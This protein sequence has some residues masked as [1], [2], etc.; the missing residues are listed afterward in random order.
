M[1]GLGYDLPDQI[2][3]QAKQALGYEIKSTAPSPPDIQ[4]LVQQEPA[5]W[6]IFSCFQQDVAEFW[7]WGNLQPVEIARL[8][9]W[10]EITPLYKLGR[11]QPARTRCAYGQGDAAF[12]RLYV[13]PNRSGRW[14][15]A[16]RVPASV[17]RELVQWVNES[18]A[19]PVGPE[20]KFCTGVPGT[21]NFDSFG[22]NSG[23]STKQPEKLSWAELLNGRW[24]GRV[25]LNG[26]DSQGG[27][28]DMA[29]AVQAAGLMR[30]GDLGDPTRKEIDRLA[31]LLL[32]YRKR[33]QF[34]NVWPQGGNPVEW[35]QNKKV[36]VCT[37]YASMIASLSALGFPVRQAD[38]PEGYRAFGGLLSISKAVTDPVQL[39]A[40]YDF[41]N[42][43]HS[44]FAGAFLLRAGY[45]N[46]VQSTSRQH[47]TPGEYA[48]WMDGK[49]A[50]QTYAG[51]FGDKS[52]AEGRVRDGGSFI[53]R[54][55]RI[56]SWNSTPRQQ[57]YF[58]GRWA[59]FISSFSPPGR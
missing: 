33:G 58:I 49:P 1:L 18:T 4:H 23:S 17:K 36:V 34:F 53:R 19:K 13:D 2:R 15:S 56:S 5:T 20:P 38:P 30:F 28:Q 52:V 40:C 46:A 12:R 42:W 41:L 35:M 32:S 10:K 50:D 57:R 31:K 47:M 43:W 21:F 27:L 39:D 54:A 11:A 45:Y 29:N 48:Y 26:F 16:P 8:R 51:P 3:E 37:M 59:E 25:G 55:C 9:R 22:Y 7:P 44:G 24:K 6:D 14:R